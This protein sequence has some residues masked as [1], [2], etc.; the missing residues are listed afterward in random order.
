MKKYVYIAL[1]AVILIAFMFGIC[2]YLL[3]TASYVDNSLYILEGKTICIDAGHGGKDPGKVGNIKNEDDLNLEVTLKLKDILMSMGANVVLTRDSENGLYEDG[4]LVWRKKD[5][6][7]IRREII[8]ESNCDIL[9]SIH[10]NSHTDDSRGAEVLYLKDHEKS[11]LLAKRI[12]EQLDNTSKYSKERNI[13]PHDD[14]YI[15]KNDNIPSVL[16]EC[17]FMSEANEEKLLNDEEYQKQ[18]SNYIALGVV[19]YFYNN[20]FAHN[21]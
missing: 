16:I 7:K 6:M 19:K 14:L 12:K 15:L 10:M 17:G 21:K 13:E 2:C 9:I 3:V 18:L 11:E 20:D 1:F 8:K 4:S 5:D